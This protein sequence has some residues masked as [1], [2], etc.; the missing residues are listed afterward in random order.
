MY[1]PETPQNSLEALS[2]PYGTISESN[3]KPQKLDKAD[4]LK[5]HENNGTP[6]RV[7]IYI[8]KEKFN[9]TWLPG[10]PYR[11]GVPTILRYARLICRLIITFDDVFKEFA[12]TEWHEAW[13]KLNDAC[14]AF[15]TVV[16]PPR[17]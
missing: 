11:T 6:Q 8:K 3:L 4:R 2:E 9:M 16:E 12:P 5:Y 1:T 17:P 13:D 14:Q 10:T 7:F 15:T